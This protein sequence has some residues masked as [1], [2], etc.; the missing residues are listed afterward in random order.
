MSTV[1]KP[2]FAAHHAAV[3]QH[4]PDTAILH[5]TGRP[6]LRD[7][8]GVSRLWRSQVEKPKTPHAGWVADEMGD[9]S[10]S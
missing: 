5:H 6:Y 3:V 9:G 7:H 1:A 10:S 4:S 8:V 2:R